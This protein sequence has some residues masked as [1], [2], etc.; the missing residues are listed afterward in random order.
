MSFDELDRLLRRAGAPVD[1]AECHGALCGALCSPTPDTDAWLAHVLEGGD[2]AGA[3]A[4]L[5]ALAADTERRLRA[6]DFEFSPCLPDDD[7]PLVE[8]VASLGEW[9]EGFLFGLGS[10]RITDYDALPDAAQEIVRDVIEMARVGAPAGDDDED[11]DEAAYSD[12]VEYLRAG[13]QLLYDELNPAP[14]NPV[15]AAPPRLQ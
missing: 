8:R 7:E 6:G 1:A 4:P 3:R 10:A 5:V 13:I 15:L 12:L 9:C 2:D 11:G 14:P